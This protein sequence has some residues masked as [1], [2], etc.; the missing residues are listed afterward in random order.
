M[1]IQYIPMRGFG[2]FQY[3]PS[4]ERIIFNLICG[5]KTDPRPRT[6]NFMLDFDLLMP[7][8]G[9]LQQIGVDA[10]G[11]RAKNPMYKT[12]VRGAFAFD[13][14]SAAIGPS[15]IEAKHVLV[16]RETGPE[17]KSQH[18]LA[19]DKTGLEKLLALV[20]SYLEDLNSPTGSQKPGLH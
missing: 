11:A 3:E 18:H 1:S 20:Q 8:I 15:T 13:Y 9:A 19:L 7:F 16:L 12:E 17:G 2:Q 4:G 10:E 5:E 14:E 6:L